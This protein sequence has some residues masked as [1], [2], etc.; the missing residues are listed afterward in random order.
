M[1]P[2]Q[3]MTKQTATRMIERARVRFTHGLQS[4]PGRLAKS[5]EAVPPDV[6]RQIVSDAERVAGELIAEI[7]TWELP[8]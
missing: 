2:P 3:I 8:R 1:R 6:R 7:E 5:L 4:L